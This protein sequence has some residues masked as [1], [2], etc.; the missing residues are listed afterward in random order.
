V[1]E[2]CSNQVQFLRDPAES[3][4]WKWCGDIDDCAGETQRFPPFKCSD[5]I[6]V[7]VAPVSVHR[8][9]E[10]GARVSGFCQSFVERC[11]LFVKT[12]SIPPLDVQPIAV[13]PSITASRGSFHET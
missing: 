4:A 12:R 5:R 2:P 6:G 7:Q 13:N 1:S 10:P 8:E 9:I 11:H 3:I